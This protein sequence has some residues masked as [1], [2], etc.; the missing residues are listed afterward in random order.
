MKKFFEAHR[1]IRARLDALQELQG[2]AEAAKILTEELTDTKRIMTLNGWGLNK[3]L[4]RLLLVRALDWSSGQVGQGM[5]P[6]VQVVFNNS[7][8]KRLYTQALYLETGATYKKARDIAAAVARLSPVMT[9]LSL[10]NNTAV[11]LGKITQVFHDVSHSVS[12]CFENYHYFVTYGAHASS[13]VTACQEAEKV[14]PVLADAVKRNGGKPLSDYEADKVY[15]TE[16][17]KRQAIL[18]MQKGRSGPR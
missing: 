1:R 12:V 15:A 4:D 8:E 13:M 14:F 18:L 2:E 16:D 7:A 9:S 6:C 3:L 10:E 17:V 11:N 5:E